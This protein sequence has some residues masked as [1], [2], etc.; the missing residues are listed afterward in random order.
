MKKLLWLAFLG[1]LLNSCATTS[2]NVTQNKI[3]IGMSKTE[4]C[5]ETMSMSAKKDACTLTY[6]EML[7][8]TPRGPYYPDT[9][10]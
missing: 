8:S 1:L 4:F 6:T 2:S 5:Y 3:R 7:K 10:M 9:Q